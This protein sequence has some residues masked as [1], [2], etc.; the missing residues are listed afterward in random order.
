MSESIS[1]EFPYEPHYAQVRGSRM[2][3]IDVGEG[4][5]T[6]IFLHGNPTS[7]Y[8]WRNII[9]HVAG[10][11]R[12]IAPDLIGMG[13]SDK[14][15]IAYRVS[16]HAA[17]LEEFIAALDLRGEQS[18]LVLVLH[19]W[20]S[21]LGLDWARRHSEQVQGLV[22]MEFIAPAPT[23]LDFPVR[24]REL[25]RSFRTPNAGRQLIIEQN[26]FVERV[27]PAGVVRGLTEGEMEQYRAPFREPTHREPTWRFPN[28]LPIAGEPIDVYAMAQAYHAWLLETDIP[29]LLFWGTP[30]A[31]ISESKAAWYAA[32]L[33]HCRSVAIGPG[34]HFVQEDNPHLIGREIAAWLNGGY[35]WL[36]SRLRTKLMVK[37]DST[38][39]ALE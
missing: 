37:E 29:K 5:A 23:W 11:A 2:H 33:R 6:A 36:D 27:L 10:A 26:A 30:G 32:T 17:Y 39:V 12:C 13:K 34:G 24:G 1:P 22:L 35:A 31:L 19:D 20:G 14:P 28:E 16:D 21:A 4:D 18:R 3:Y 8:L 9:P 38:A 15:S 25:F 7:C